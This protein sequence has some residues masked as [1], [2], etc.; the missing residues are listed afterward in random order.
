MDLCEA[1]ERAQSLS[2]RLDA[3][4]GAAASAE[5]HAHQPLA[6]AGLPAGFPAAALMVPPCGAG[7]LTTW[8][9]GK[10]P[11]A[12]WRRSTGWTRSRSTP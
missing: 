6:V 2:K 10:R 8:G 7:C 11:S 3:A 9:C 12:R 4:P 1:A 5:R